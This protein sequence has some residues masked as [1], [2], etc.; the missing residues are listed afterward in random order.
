MRTQVVTDSSSDG[1]SRSGASISGSRRESRPTRPEGM[2]KAG[3]GEGEER[4]C[5]QAGAVSAPRRAPPHH[6]I[7]RA[8]QCSF[9][10]PLTVTE[11]S[12]PLWPAARCH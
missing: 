11:A 1:W 3:G 7:V 12:V 5:Q 10:S 8:D 2:W 4:S 6:G 9:L